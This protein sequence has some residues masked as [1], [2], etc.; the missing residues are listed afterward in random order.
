MVRRRLGIL[1][2]LPGVSS[3]MEKRRE[4]S[5]E[6]ILGYTPEMVYDIVADLNRL[7]VHSD[8]SKYHH[9]LSV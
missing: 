9:A 4:Y 7:T 2:S 5:E 6:R 8:P 3:L 1:S